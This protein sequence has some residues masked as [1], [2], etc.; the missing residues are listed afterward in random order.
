VRSRVNDRGFVSRHAL[1]G[2]RGRL[3]SETDLQ[4]PK[5][6]T[7]IGATEAHPRVSLTSSF[8][9]T[10]RGPATAG[11]DLGDSW[12]WDGATWTMLN[13]VG[14]TARAGGVMIILII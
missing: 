11:G 2:E 12:R 4:K 14:P 7:D 5:E 6:S 8:G 10:F 13:V 1:L 3:S 9:P